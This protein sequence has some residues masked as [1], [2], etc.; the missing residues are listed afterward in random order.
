MLMPSIMKIIAQ[1]NYIVFFN[2]GDVFK[3]KFN[4]LKC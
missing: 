2:Y 4:K 1:S 3:I